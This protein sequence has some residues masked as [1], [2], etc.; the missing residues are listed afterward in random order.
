[1]VDTKAKR[2]ELNLRAIKKSLKQ[3]DEWKETE[4]ED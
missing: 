1:M 4:L 3:S 2:L